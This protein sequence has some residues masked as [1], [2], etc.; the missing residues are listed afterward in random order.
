MS[1]PA[2]RLLTKARDNAHALFIEASEDAKSAEAAQ[3]LLELALYATSL[4][5]DLHRALNPDGIH[6]ASKYYEEFPVL[7]SGVR[8]AN[9]QQLEAVYALPLGEKRPFKS[10]AAEVGPATKWNDVR[11]TI[12]RHAYPK[13]DR[14][15]NGVEESDVS[16]DLAQKIRALPPIS[17]HHAERWARLMAEYFAAGPGFS[18][19]AQ[20]ISSPARTKSR[21]ISKRKIRLRE[22]Y[23]GDE[24]ETKQSREG[25]PRF[26]AKSSR[27]KFPLKELDAVSATKLQDRAEKV[28]LDSLR[29][30]RESEQMDS[31]A[32]AFRDCL[33]AILRG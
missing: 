16:P 23:G 6:E 28:R 7:A 4:V 25:E 11:D 26:Y 24:V 32:N 31:V 18:E 1:V 2:V 14:I 10:A 22:H 8:R 12:V 15:R 9:K 3:C 33:R 30:P 21:N 27:G 13:F 17:R 20:I 19:F 5:D 29:T